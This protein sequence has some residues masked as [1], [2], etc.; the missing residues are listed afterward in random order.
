MQPTI[1]GL[2]VGLLLGMALAFDGFGSM[3]IVAFCGAVGYVV[4]KV[5]QGEIDLTPYLG[6][7]GRIRQ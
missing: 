1:V 6:G 5:V 3:L 7:G 2:F 4:M